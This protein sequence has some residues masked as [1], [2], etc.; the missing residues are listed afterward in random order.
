MYI[1]HGIAINY[2]SEAPNIAGIEASVNLSISPK[3]RLVLHQRYLRKELFEGSLRQ[4]ELEK[5]SSSQ[6][7]LRISGTRHGNLLL[8]NIHIYKYI[9][10]YIYHIYHTILY[11]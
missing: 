8:F 6:Q 9:H 10:I 7:Q 11:I 3:E 5:C 1:F 4:L 2:G